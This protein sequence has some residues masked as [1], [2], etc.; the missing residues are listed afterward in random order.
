MKKSV[1]F[2]VSPNDFED[3]EDQYENKK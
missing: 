1:A 2:K 3:D